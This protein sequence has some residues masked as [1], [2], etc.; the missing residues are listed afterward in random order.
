VK[1]SNLRPVLTIDGK[2]ILRKMSIDATVIIQRDTMSAGSVS[3]PKGRISVDQPASLDVNW[4][5]PVLKS[6][7]GSKY[8]VAI[9][10]LMLVGF[11]LA[12]FAGNAL[13]FK[14]RDALNTYA[15]GLRDLGAL[16]WVARIG[17]LVVFVVH[18]YLAVKLS[19]RNKAA[20]PDKYQH[21]ATVRASFASRT[22]LLS[23]L[24]ILVFTVY[25]LAH[26]T[27]A[28]TQH[29]PSGENFHDMVETGWNPKNPAEPRY[30]VYAMV[31]HGFSNPW[32]SISYIVAQLILGLH[33]SHGISSTMQTIGW[34]SPRCWP[35][36]RCIGLT[37][38]AIIVLGNISIPAAI[39]AGWVK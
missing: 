16:L 32:V 6:T 35:M 15:R 27:F 11:L 17:L 7:V 29:G 33:L 4:F 25:H 14:G 19:L 18:I 21:P 1:L 30:D 9:T 23:G 38:T 34:N 26:Y 36:I 5:G 22:M 10:G 28:V 3:R 31:I 20:R 12:H 8:L 37:I 13:V 2:K 39:W 24:L